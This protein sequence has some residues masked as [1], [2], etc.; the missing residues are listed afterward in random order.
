MKNQ[1]S[2]ADWMEAN[3]YPAYFLIIPL[4][5]SLFN[6]QGIRNGHISKLEGKEQKPLFTASQWKGTSF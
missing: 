2:S 5:L 1:E 3:R 4:S 6:S